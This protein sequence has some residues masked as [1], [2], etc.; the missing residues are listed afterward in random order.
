M[1]P[2]E[3]AARA[4]KVSKYVATIDALAVTHSLDPH[5]HAEFLAHAVSGMTETDWQAL[6]VTAGCYPPSKITVEQIRNTY[7]E[8]AN[9]KNRTLA[10]A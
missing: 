6:A 9:A 8:R 3:S 5:E 7:V 1:S 2:A 4:A 10:S